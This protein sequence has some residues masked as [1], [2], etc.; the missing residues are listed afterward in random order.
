MGERAGALQLGYS[1]GVPPPNLAAGETGDADLQ[2]DL[3]S[4]A[5]FPRVSLEQGRV[6]RSRSQAP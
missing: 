3:M 2:R 6:R 5:L 4:L 1:S